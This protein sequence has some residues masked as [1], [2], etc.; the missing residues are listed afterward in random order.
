MPSNFAS[1][2]IGA[3]GCQIKELANKA[4]GAQIKVMSDKDDSDIG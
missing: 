2:L 1:K 3:K 4:K